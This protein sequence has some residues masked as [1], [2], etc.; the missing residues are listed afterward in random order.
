MLRWMRRRLGGKGRGALGAM[1]NGADEM[2]HA[3]ALRG[4]EDLDMRHQRTIPAPSPGDHLFG[5][6]RVVLP[7]PV[8]PEAAKDE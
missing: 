7:R 2:W 4:R 6:G 3:T 5:D 8:R 1:L